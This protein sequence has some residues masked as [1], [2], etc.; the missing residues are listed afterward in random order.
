VKRSTTPLVLASGSAVGI[1]TIEPCASQR[2]SDDFMSL[3]ELALRWSCTQRT[4]RQKI[5]A[6]GLGICPAGTWLISRSRVAAYEASLFGKPRDVSNDPTAVDQA[7]AR[8]LTLNDN[9]KKFGVTEN[10]ELKRRLF[11]LAPPI[12]RKVE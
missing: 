6:K 2:L 3:D 8:A 11:K 9:L 7:S 10:A 12:S 4:A 1:S 5:Q